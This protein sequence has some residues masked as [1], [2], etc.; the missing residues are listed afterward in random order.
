M[1]D[2]VELKPTIPPPSAPLI[3]APLTEAIFSATDYV[4]S[5]SGNENG[6]TYFELNWQAGQGQNRRQNLLTTYYGGNSGEPSNETLTEP[7]FSGYEGNSSA[8]NSFGDGG[9]QIEPN[10][11]GVNSNERTSF[12]S[13]DDSNH[14]SWDDFVNLAADNKDF[15]GFR[16][17]SS[18]FWRGVRQISEAK[19]FETG[20]GIKTEGVSKYDELLTEMK[21]EKLSLDDL[22]ET[23]PPKD[24]E[25]FK[26]R[27]QI[28]KTFG[29][30]IFKSDGVTLNE[31]GQSRVREIA[32][33]SGQIVALPPDVR[34]ELREEKNS[35]VGDTVPV[36][37]RREIIA[38]AKKPVMFGEEVAKIPLSE[39]TESGELKFQDKSSQIAVGNNNN[40]LLAENG[41]TRVVNNPVSDTSSNVNS[42]VRRDGGAAMGGALINGSFASI[43]NFKNAENKEISG[44]HLVGNTNF[45]G[46]QSF[47]AGATGAMM[48]AAIGSLIPGSD[49]VIG[50][51][52]G[53][54]SGIVVGVEAD[55]GLRWLSGD[56]PTAIAPSGNINLLEDNS[57]APN[58]Q[59]VSA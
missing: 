44:S 59:P 53:F 41:A 56:R 22:A 35:P 31:T 38:D 43:D 46:S 23:L 24:R 42:V 11:Y 54:I 18:D 39:K 52:V 26:A 33:E 51:V 7:V 36:L 29:A 20:D 19:T 3:P 48:S 57:F 4:P 8:R 40:P 15:S 37:T 49:A 28:D 30:N 5:A 9:N 50:G 10:Y 58:L 13:S 17:E 14:L 6:G 55:Q 32:F 47:A 45:D 16:N 34:Q 1:S 12:Y 27:Y 21:S 25:I 2:S